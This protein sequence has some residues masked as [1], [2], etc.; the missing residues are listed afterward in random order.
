MRPVYPQPGHTEAE[1]HALLATKKFVFADCLTITTL[2]G[3]TL[4]YTTAQKTVSVY[5]LFDPSAPLKSDYT[6]NAVKISGLKT[7]IG[8]GVEVDEQD[9]QFDYNADQKYM[10]IPFS[11]ALARGK[12][13]GAGIRRDRYFAEVWGYMNSSTGV[14]VPT[15]FIGGTPMFIGKFSNV[16][17]AGRSSATITVKSDLVLMNIQMPRKLYQPSCTHT[18]FDSG[19]LLDREDF[20]VPGLT[21]TGSTASRIKWSSITNDYKFGTM[22]FFDEAGVLQVRTIEDVDFGNKIAI[23]SL[24]LDYNPGAGRPFDAFVGCI[25]TLARCQELNNEEHFQ[26]FPFVPVAETA[27]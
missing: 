23:L 13:D 7:T 20:R 27:N 10:G 3:D 24:P 17:D 22:H 6:S 4:R 1:I 11:Q 26:A 21:E 2:G 25:R 5:P 18:L 15:D 19:C 16:R 9:L 8:I 12:F 14:E